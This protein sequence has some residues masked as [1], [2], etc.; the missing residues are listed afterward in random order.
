MLHRESV[1]APRSAVLAHSREIPDQGRVKRLCALLLL[2]LAHACDCDDPLVAIDPEPGRAGPPKQAVPDAGVPLPVDAGTP[3]AGFLPDAG[4]APDAGFPSDA[5]FAPD[6]GNPPIGTG[7]VPV[8]EGP[9]GP[10]QIAPG[11]PAD[12][13]GE[14]Q[15]VPGT[16][17][18]ETVTLTFPCPVASVTVTAYDPDFSENEMIAYDSSGTELSHVWFV[19]D[20]APGTLT[21][22]TRTVL[23]AGAPIEEV[24]L[25]P[26]P[27]DYVSYGNISYTVP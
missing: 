7:D 23:T 11:Y 14:F 8:Y 4:F 17:Y 27:L 10:V 20:N 16:G 13:W 15:S 5:G 22:D 3:D 25:H 24:L 19:G 6:A 2:I 9:C 18:Q 26:D 12:L 1:G 21:T